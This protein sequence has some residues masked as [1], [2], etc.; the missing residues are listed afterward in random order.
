M[1]RQLSVIAYWIGIAS[2]VLALITRGLA[3]IG[4]QV[5]PTAQQTVGSR[6]PVSYRTFLEGAVLFF[7]MAIAGSVLSWAKTQRSPEGR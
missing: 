4:V 6:V 1:E 3:V 2:T 7:V 5:F